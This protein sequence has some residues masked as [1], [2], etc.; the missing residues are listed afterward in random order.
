MIL[1]DWGG[2]AGRAPGVAL[3]FGSGLIGGPTVRSLQRAAGTASVRRMDWTWS[4]HGTG[5]AATV[6]TAARE[7]LAAREGARLT[8]VWAAGR[9]GF[10][11]NAAA[12][13]DE[14]AS[15]RAVLATARR[16]GADL[17]PEQRGFVH[18][19]SAGGLFEGQVACGRA[20][21]SAPLRPYGEG[22]LAQERLVRADESLGRRHIVRPS[23][24]YGYAR[25]ARKGLI[26]SLIAAALRSRPAT[27]MGALTTQ[28]DYVYAP[29]IGRFIAARVLELDPVDAPV[30]TSLLASGRPTAIFEIIRLIESR[31]DAPLLLQ[32]DPRP[33][34][35]R[36][37]TFLLS[38]LPAGFRPTR[39]VEGVALT[40]TAL[41]ADRYTGAAV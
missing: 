37:N 30:E 33:E 26:A 22:K 18:V 1:L 31:F 13:D 20:A 23:S 41:A 28:R 16:I 9:S 2:T 34:N 27:I 32:I 40:A 3:V 11:A 12:M 35:A 7:A 4:R 19:S 29:D 6:E 15:L 14:L 25:G 5:E 24:V 36:D 38:G 8:I 21:E 17:P 10:E 39:L